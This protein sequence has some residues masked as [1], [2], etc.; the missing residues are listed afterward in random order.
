L[1]DDDG[2]EAQAGSTLPSIFKETNLW[3]TSSMHGSVSNDLARAMATEISN[4]YVKNVESL[5]SLI[6]YF[7]EIYHI[8]TSTEF[9]SLYIV[10][11]L[12][13]ESEVVFKDS[14]VI[15]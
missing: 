12:R 2:V 13:E 6:Q 3:N 15:F 14:A 11:I 7:R 5:N 8:P 10:G 4:F 9:E 1:K